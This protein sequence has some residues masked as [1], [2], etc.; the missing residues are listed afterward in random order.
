MMHESEFYCPECDDGLDHAPSATRRQFLAR[1]GAGAAALA[2][3]TAPT[4]VSA[5][6]PA[7]A[8]RR[9]AT[10]AEGLVRELYQG[11]SEAQR[12]NLVYPWNHMTRGTPSRLL[13]YNSAIFNKRLEGN[14][15]PAQ[16]DLVR[17]ILRAVLSSDEAYTRISR[18]NNWDQ[19]GGYE[20]N[21]CVIFGEPSDGNRFSWVFSG[22]HL[23][24]R[25]D[26]NSEPDTAFGGP[27]Y[28]GHEADGRSARNVFNYQT[29]EVQAVFDALTE[30]QRRQAVAPGN[31]GDREEA[32][33]FRPADQA[34]P[35]IVYNDLTQDQKTL[36]AGVMR[37][38]LAPFR[39]ADGD[40]VM[41]LIRTNGGMER[42]HLAFYRDAGNR[43][44][45]PW[46]YWRLEGP[47]FIWNYRITPH[48]HCYVNI[49]TA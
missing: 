17:R 18:N 2:V 45:A 42:I 33:R 16:R 27:M 37:T 23:T 15:T 10:P 34:R 36:V 20:G 21:G 39:Q 13:T 43:R 9:E 26:G 44:E 31:P 12:R 8:Q 25:C 30:A 32:I 4:L 14:Y 38:L 24:L 35:G 5:Q 28:Y 19:T 49:K 7:P 3:G 48:V 1:L 6:A 29:R 46:S 41:Q 22:H 47:G 11:L 40:E